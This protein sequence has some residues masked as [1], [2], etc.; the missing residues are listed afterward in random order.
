MILGLLRELSNS[1]DER[2]ETIELNRHRNTELVNLEHAFAILA[3]TDKKAV[4][5]Q[6]HAIENLK[7]LNQTELE[8]LEVGYKKDF[9]ILHKLY[10]IQETHN[11]IPRSKVRI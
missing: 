2:K 6:K 10:D 3:S 4:L 5:Y 8:R 7:I 1:L 9:I 11:L